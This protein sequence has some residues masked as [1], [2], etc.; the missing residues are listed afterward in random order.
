MRPLLV[1]RPEPG[2]A[3]SVA[4][5]RAMGLTVLGTPLFAIDAVPWTVPDPAAFAGILAGSANLFRLAGPGLARLARLPVLAVGAET[6]QAAQDA[7]FAVAQVGEGGLAE[8]ARNLAPGRYLRLSGAD[9][10]PLA[11]PPGVAVETI[12]VYAARPLP[13]DPAAQALLQG[14]CVVALHSGEAARH[15]AAECARLGLA[16]GNVALACLAPRIGPKAGPGWQAVE[17]SAKRRDQPLL[18][19]ARQMCQNL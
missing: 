18:A 11:P 12:T 15:F 5:A 10:A 1:L 14:P 17:I 4:A 9:P 7:G 3:A 19:L 2:N 16:R 13:L 8:V 6:A